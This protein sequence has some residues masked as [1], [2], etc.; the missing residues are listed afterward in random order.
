M[1]FCFCLFSFSVSLRSGGW[2]REWVGCGEASDS[3]VD[4]HTCNANGEVSLTS[5]PKARFM[6]AFPTLC[7]LGQPVRRIGSHAYTSSDGKKHMPFRRCSLALRFMIVNCRERLGTTTLLACY[8]VSF[9]SLFLEFSYPSH[10]CPPM[11]GVTL[12]F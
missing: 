9:E 7:P 6:T 11:L 10:S 3:E 8:S 5:G 1:G 4:G 2:V 12:S